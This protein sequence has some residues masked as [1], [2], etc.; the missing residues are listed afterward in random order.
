MRVPGS[1]RLEWWATPLD[2]INLH[3]RSLQVVVWFHC[4]CAVMSFVNLHV[5][6]Y[7]KGFISTSLASLTL[8]DTI[9]GVSLK[10]TVLSLNNFVC[11]KV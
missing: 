5:Q 9:L 7:I 6:T 2:K 10:V 11:A 1:G 3:F 8:P 4:A